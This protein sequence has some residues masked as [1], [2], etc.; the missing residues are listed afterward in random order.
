MINTSTEYQNQIAKK[1]Q[2]WKIKAQIDYSD[3]GI[4][5]SIQA[6][7]I[8]PDRQ[9]DPSQLADGIE[10]PTY[11]WWDWGNFSWDS[12]LRAEEL[13]DN[14]K[15]ALSQQLS[16]QDGTFRRF[17]GAIAGFSCA[18]FTGSLSAVAPVNYYPTFSV[19]FSPR[20]VTSVKAVF[21]NKLNEWGVDFDIEL[22]DSNGVVQHTSNVTGNTSVKY[23]EIIS[24]ETDIVESRLTIYEWN[25][26]GT[27]AKVIETFTSYSQTYESDEL[28]STSIY[29]ETGPKDGTK[30]IGNVSSNSC[31]LSIL[32]T[33]SKFDNE[34]SSSPLAG[35]V[36]KN[37][38]L[39]LTGSLF[40]PD[41]GIYEDIPLGVY[42]SQKWVIDNNKMQ[43]KVNGLDIVSIMNDRRYTKSQFITAPIDQ[44]FTYTTTAD[45]N[46]FS[47]D[48]VTVTTDEMELGNEASYTSFESGKYTFSGFGV[49][50][51]GIESKSFARW[52]SY[53]GTA[54]KQV[55]YTYT[56]GTTV[57]L[58]FNNDVRTSSSAGLRWFINWKTI[59]EY[60][61]FDPRDG[62]KFTPEN[63]SLTTQIFDL[64]VLFE[65]SGS[66]LKPVVEEIGIT[67]SQYASLYSLAAKVLDDFDD[68]T[69]LL[70]DNY[71]IDDSYGDYEIEKAYLEPIPYKDLLQLIA[72]AAIGYGYQD[73][74]GGF[75]MEIQPV[76][77]TIRKTY[78]NDNVFDC[79]N[80]SNPETLYNRVTVVVNKLIQGDSEEVAN[81]DISLPIGA[82]STYTIE[83]KDQPVD[84]LTYGS[85]P[86]GVTRSSTTEYTWGVIV[87]FT[88]ASG[89]QQDFT[90][91]VDGKIYS[92]QGIKEITIDDTES[93][94]KSGII[95][96][97]IDNP[98]IQSEENAKAI[99][100]RMIESFKNEKR[101][102]LLDSAIDPSLELKDTIEKNGSFYTITNQEIKIDSG[103]ANHLIGGGK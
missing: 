101:L 45:F 27:K 84:T 64:M 41:S 75:N 98:L 13:T 103:A 2:K 44:T 16:Y 30:P 96:Y 28:F 95:E 18:T 52:T 70:N 82:V 97:R 46:S 102:I 34:N 74:G 21:D 73:R 57:R 58:I 31:N 47:L 80:P 6:G 32:N 86:G 12:H 59:P 81:V 19:T 43:A 35:N 11:I 1:E 100:T 50:K 26:P 63:L 90:F 24:E 87:E 79:V 49:A 37:R 94:R 71:R 78:T 20:S 7:Q 9:S 60:I 17:G 36:I 92:T 5:N 55:T 99:A 89:S 14:Q 38:R 40:L 68:E 39:T 67:L 62:I 83:F 53:S 88:N 15:G 23:N 85:L 4:D 61:E 77:S 8:Y 76:I 48:N 91:T 56:P 69:K 65:S 54:T 29:E 25:T 93:I 33:N 10:S 3:F 22:I 51:A 66:R 72:E 42:Y